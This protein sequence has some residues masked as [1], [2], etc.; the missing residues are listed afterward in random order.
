MAM[1]TTANAS[2]I[3][4]RSTEPTSHLAR[5]SAFLMDP[6]GALV[7]YYADEDVLTENWQP[8]DFEPGPTVFAEWAV[9]GGLDGNSRRQKSA[10]PGADGKFL[11]GKR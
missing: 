9:A 2:L 6:A 7:E 10:A 4:H 3:S 8:R 5:A 11:T 1:D